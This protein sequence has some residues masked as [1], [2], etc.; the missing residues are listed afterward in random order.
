[1]EGSGLIDVEVWSDAARLSFESARDRW[2]S[3]LAYEQ[4]WLYLQQAMR[5]GGWV[6]RHADG[7][8]AVSKDYVGA[9]GTPPIF[10]N[11]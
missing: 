9:A 3:S 5:R 1:M 4:N 10:L 2:G 8:A 6:L 11:F 7:W